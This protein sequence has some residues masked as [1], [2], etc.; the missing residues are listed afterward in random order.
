MRSL[1]RC[2]EKIVKKGL[3]SACRCG[4]DPGRF[5]VDDSLWFFYEFLSSPLAC[6]VRF[7]RS[8]LYRVNPY[9]LWVRFFLHMGEY[10]AM[11]RL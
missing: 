10:L 3:V 11:C 4:F 8:L 2:N 6:E 9:R 7:T 5:I 1:W